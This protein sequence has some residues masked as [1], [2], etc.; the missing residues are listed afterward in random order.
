MNYSK[1]TDQLYIGTTPKVSDYHLLHDINVSL[2][3]NM[4]IG[5]PPYRDPISPPVRS[6]WLPWI[7]SPLFPLPI[8]WL[9]IGVKEAL[10][11]IHSG[12]VVYAHCARGRHRGP[13]MGACILIA[14][15]QSPE[16]AINMIKQARPVS[17]PH[18]WYIRS[19]ILKFA[20]VW[21]ASQGS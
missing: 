8:L 16:E 10:E 15:G 1:I 2:V 20:R 18:V 9:N 4:R 17:D 7:D 3:I 5:M 12:G 21:A 14:Q 13:A 11:V 19:R 6:L